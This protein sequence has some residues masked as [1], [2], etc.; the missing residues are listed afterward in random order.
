MIEFLDKDA[1]GLLEFARNQSRMEESY[2][3]ILIC[4]VLSVR[5][6]LAHGLISL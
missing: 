4:S 1:Q 5:Q 2:N 3:L 6:M